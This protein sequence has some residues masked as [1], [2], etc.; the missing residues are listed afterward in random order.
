VAISDNIK[1]RISAC[2]NRNADVIYPPVDIGRFNTSQSNEDFYLIVSALVPYKRVDLAIDVFNKN[3]K[4]LVIIGTGD[5]QETLMKKSKGNIEF[6]GWLSDD[7]ISS[8]YERCRA[9]IFPGEEDFGIVPVEAQACGKP[10]IA[11]AKGGA[12]ETV[13]GV[14]PCHP[15]PPLL[16]FAKQSEGGEG[17]RDLDSSVAVLPQ[18]DSY[19]SRPQNGSKCLEPKDDRAATGVFF[20]E[21]TPKA[22]SSA[23][24]LFEKNSDKF[25]PEKIRENALRFGR[26]IF[27]DKISRYIQERIDE[28]KK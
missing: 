24:D 7:K 13:V 28:K 5:Y 26:K 25:D 16:R 11:Y 15:E 19:D 2:Y 6:L 22:L 27:K 21:Q 9:L 20:Y 23:I 1:N 17:S 18:N 3:G 4:R 8:Y 10:V 12:L 14:N